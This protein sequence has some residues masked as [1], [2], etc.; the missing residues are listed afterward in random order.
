MRWHAGVIL[1]LTLA[2]C[3]KDAVAPPAETANEPPVGPTSKQEPPDDLAALGYVDGAAAEAARE[4]LGECPGAADGSELIGT[5][6][7]VWQLGDWQNSEPLT[8]AGLRGRVVVVRFWMSPGCPFCEKSM[9]A[10]QVLAEEFADQA[11]TI[12]G[13]YHAKPV[14]SVA[15]L[16]EPSKVAQ[17]WG[18]TFPIAFDRKWKTLRS[19]WLDGKH[20]RHATSVT[21]VIGKDGRIVH[22]HP[23]PV[24]HPSDDPAEAQQN[25]DYLALRAAIVRAVGR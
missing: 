15:D 1:C 19:W 9:P 25:R 2:G 13:A 22:I 21:F 10:L 17:A 18:V 14:G 3:R 4:R 6:V 20:H 5:R 7:P 16:S 8:L 23:G 12:V 11:V 24:F